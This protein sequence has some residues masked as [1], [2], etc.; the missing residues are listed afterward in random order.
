MGTIEIKW[1]APRK[2]VNPFVPNALFFYPLKIFFLLPEIIRFS[3]VF[4]G[5]R[6]SALGTNGFNYRVKYER[7]H[8]IFEKTEIFK[9][10]SIKY[11]KLILPAPCIS[12]S[13]IKTKINLNT[14]L[15][16]LIGFYKSL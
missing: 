9:P 11:Y 13:C 7:L 4:R 16:Y 3:N 10:D 12:E 14:S 6:K 5:W 15:W 1:N 2:C 8:S